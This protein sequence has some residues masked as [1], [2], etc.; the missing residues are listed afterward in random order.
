M[1]LHRQLF[2]VLREQINCGALEV[3]QALPNE[4]ELCEQFGVSRITVRR[5]LQDLSDQ[6]L[7]QRRHGRGTYVL[8]RDGPTD[9]APSVLSVKE[10]LRKVQLETKAEIVDVAVRNP[11]YSVASALALAD[12]PSALYVLRVRKDKKSGEPLL[13]SEAWLPPQYSDLVT[14]K[15]L[16]SRALYEIMGDGGFEMG[17]VAQELTAEIADPLKSRLLE[18]S[19]GSAL[20]R[21]N[22]LIYDVGDNP[23]Q[24]LTLYLSP[25]R[26]RILMD[27]TADRLDTTHSGLVA[28]DV[29]RG[30]LAR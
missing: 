20:I 12:E 21:V 19:I 3:G 11:P 5:A 6:G 9:R 24:H 26:S 14:R 22:R 8:P 15:A 2:L 29:R 1:A 7:V 13:I 18:V 23:V 30:R 17:R 10:G 28:H 16:K 25:E 4:Q 27:I